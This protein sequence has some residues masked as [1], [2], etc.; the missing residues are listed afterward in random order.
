MNEDMDSLIHNQTWDL[1]E[2]PNDK[3]TLTNKRVYKLKDEVGGKKRY[4]EILIVKGFS[5]KKDIKSDE[6][7]LPYVKMT[8]I[9]KY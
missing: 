1:V 8:F 3:R 5:Q 9:K 6:I 2:L 7:L 4:K